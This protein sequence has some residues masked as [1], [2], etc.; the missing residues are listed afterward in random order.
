MHRHV[1]ALNLSIRLPIPARL[2]SILRFSPRH[3]RPRATVF[4]L[5]LTSTAT[6]LCLS[7][8]Q[9]IET[10]IPTMR[11]FGVYKL[12]V[13]QGNYLSQ[14]MV[15]K[16]KEGQSRQQVRLVL[17]TPLITSAFRDNRWDYVYEY[18]RQGKVL[19]HRQFS[20]FF[21]EDKLARW[22][23]DEMP[24]SA[25]ELNKV[26]SGKSLGHIPSA[27]DPGFFGWFWDIFKR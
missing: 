3:A 27:D 13:N 2:R 21:V 25:A 9:T 18:T 26:A 8:C 4:A 7:A 17:G 19:E 24:V 15:S 12:D 1:A 20:V 5:A 14:D 11:S 23:G 16:L 10:Y 22:E 6:L